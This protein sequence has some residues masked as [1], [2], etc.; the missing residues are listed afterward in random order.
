MRYKLF[1]DISLPTTSLKRSI[2]LSIL[3]LALH[4][5]SL[6]EG[7]QGKNLLLILRETALIN[8]LHFAYKNHS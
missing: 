4:M 7:N 2:M 6:S 5:F 8:S 1:S 3:T